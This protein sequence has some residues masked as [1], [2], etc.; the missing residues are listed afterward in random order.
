MKDQRL[1]IRTVNRGGGTRAQYND[2]VAQ[3]H[4]ATYLRA[5]MGGDERVIESSERKTKKDK[6]G[7]YNVIAERKTRETRTGIKKE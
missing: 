4:C 1:L 5:K 6:Q 3:S 7:E 2:F